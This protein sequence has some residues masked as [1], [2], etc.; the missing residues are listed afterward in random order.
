MTK[1]K[2]KMTVLH[3]AEHGTLRD[4]LV[5]LRVILAGALDDE[6]TQPRDLS[7]LVLR[8]KEVSAEIASI[9]DRAK[10]E[11]R[12]PPGDASFDPSTI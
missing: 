9:D 1:P 2:F 3:A 12:Q 11:A 6:R 10:A 7:A 8:L 4:L 5:A